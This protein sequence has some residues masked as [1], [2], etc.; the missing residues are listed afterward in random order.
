VRWNLLLAGI[1]ASWGF[2]SV[3]ASG[4]ELP[5]EV[6]VFWRC[7][8][9]A[10]ALPFV[11]LLLRGR[12]PFRLARHRLRVLAL[13]ALLAGH[14]VLFFAAIKASSVAVAILTVYTAPIFVA[15]LAPRFLPERRSRV[16]L[17][18]LAVSAPG[19]VLIA[20]AGDAGE[21]PSAAAIALGL[22]AAITYAFLIIGVKRIT[23]EV[24]PFSFAFWQY[25]VVSVALAPFLLTADRV[26][27]TA[28]EWPAVVA[29]GILL[30]AATGA[31]YIWNLRHVKAQAA[32]LL[33]YVEPVSAAL[34]AWAILGEELGWAVVLGGAAVLAGGAIVVVREEPDAPPRE[35]PA[36]HEPSRIVT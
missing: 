11:L 13:G 30:T 27:P 16:A 23:N 28:G 10:L 35:A 17:V 32:G 31:L 12:L 36:L 21:P 8:L 9:A 20:L 33:S 25:T 3:I 19:L 22:G 14:W 5:A 7:L 18:A 34:L 4:I 26:L 24:S 2:V 15:L 1:A 29:L 6:L